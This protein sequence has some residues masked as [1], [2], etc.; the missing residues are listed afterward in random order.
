M[1]SFAAF[2]DHD[3][4]FFIADLLGEDDGVRYEVFARGPD[5][6]VDLRH[7]TDPEEAP[8]VVQCKRYIRSTYSDLKRAA[9]EEAETLS[10]SGLVPAS[11]RL[12]TTL[13][14]TAAN[15][16]ELAAI[17]DDHVSGDEDIL[18]AGDLETLLDRHGEVERRH[19]KLWLTG[20]TQL[21]AILNSAIYQRSRQLFE[22]TQEA[23]PRYVETKA[24]FN[25]RQRLR[26]QKVLVIAGLPGIGKTTLARVLLAD[27]ALDEFEPI[28]ISKDAEEANTLYSP[29]KM[30]AFYYDD[31]LGRT[32]LQDRLVKNEDR[33]IAQL[34]RRVIASST[35]LFIM[36]T[37]EHILSQA[38][39]FYEELRREGIDTKRYLLELEEYSRLDRAR[40]FY[41]HIWSSGQLDQGSRE[42]LITGRAYERISTMTITPRG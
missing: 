6:G 31:F 37:R 39:E 22:E 28:E 33:R 9:R 15:K 42:E 35:S 41:N 24:F 23:L 30:Q 20:G 7:F 11:Y 29:D 5:R 34:I 40:I 26:E 10:R 14:L 38:L 19:P 12:V 36:T 17:L 18:A 16:V 2:S 32:F 4:E 21:D 8:D 1:R 27:A 13:E 3:F 25:A